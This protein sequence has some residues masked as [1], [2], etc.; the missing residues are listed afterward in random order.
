MPRIGVYYSRLIGVNSSRRKFVTAVSIVKRSES[1]GEKWADY[2]ASQSLDGGS[3][4]M[5]TTVTVFPIGNV[6]WIEFLK[7]P[8]AAAPRRARRGRRRRRW[9]LLREHPTQLL[10]RYIEG[11]GQRQEIIPGHRYVGRRSFYF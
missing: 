4:E 7:E 10:R 2:G 9:R 11:L 6:I 8:S 3:S 5:T 1:A